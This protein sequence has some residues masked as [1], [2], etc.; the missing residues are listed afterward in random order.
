MLQVCRFYDRQPSSGL[1]EM[2]TFKKYSINIGER[3][4]ED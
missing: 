1:L 2:P 3:Q 4:L